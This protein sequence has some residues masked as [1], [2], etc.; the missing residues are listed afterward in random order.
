MDGNL[1]TVVAF[2]GLDVLLRNRLVA[3]GITIVHVLWEELRQNIFCR[4]ETPRI[5]KYHVDQ[6]ATKRKQGLVQLKT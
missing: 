2:N 3:C 6:F 5:G 4:L 1:I